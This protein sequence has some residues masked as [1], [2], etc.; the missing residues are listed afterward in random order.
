MYV[1]IS[2]KY[3]CYFVLHTPHDGVQEFTIPNNKLNKT[4]LLRE[5]ASNGVVAEPTKND[6]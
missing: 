5:L 4:D 2:T 1:L 6:L 3:V